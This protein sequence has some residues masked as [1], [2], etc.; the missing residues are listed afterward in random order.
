MLLAEAPDVF[1]WVEFGRIS[2]Q[3]FQVDLISQAGDKF[4]HQPTSMNGQSVP[5]DQQLGADVPLEVFQELD[6]LRS[7]DAA[8]EEPEVKVPDGNPRHGRKALP[9]ERVLQHWR[10]ASGSPGAN[11]MRPL[12]QTA[13]VYKDYGALLS[14]GF[15]FI[16]GQ[17]TL[18]Q[19][20]I[21]GSSRCVARP[22]GRWQ[23]QPN[24]RRIRHT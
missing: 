7:L 10:L 4:A 19:R 5:D 13:L 15:F 6:Y 20:R 24:E 14:E 12:A 21:A 8:R 9:I 3:G 23:L 18:F 2:R 16:S 11:A 22:V 17:R 1:D